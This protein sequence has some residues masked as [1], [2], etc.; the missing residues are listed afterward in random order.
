MDQKNVSENESINLLEIFSVLIKHRKLIIT[1]TLLSVV[2]VLIFS[3]LS[4]I[5]PND[6]SFLP[7]EYT[8]KSIVK[9]NSDSSSDNI[10]TMINASG[11]GS[12]AGL[13][14]ISTGGNS[15]AAWAIELCKTR[16]VLDEI[17]NEFDL[18]EKYTRKSKYPV[19]DARK[20]ILKNLNIEESEDTGSLIIKYTD[21]DKYLAA[22]IVNKLVDILEAS[23][24]KIDKKNNETDI[25]ILFKKVNDKKIYIKQ[26][27]DQLTEFQK[28]YDILDPYIMSEEITRKAMDLRSN[29][30]SKESELDFLKSNFSSNSPKVFNKELELQAAKKLLEDVQEGRGSAKIPA[31]SEMPGLIVEYEEKKT[32]IDAQRAIYTALLQQYEMLRLKQTGTTPTFQVIEKAEI[33]LI[34]SGPSRGKICII[35][36]FIGFFFSIVLAFLK[37]F[38]LNLK[39]DPEAMAKLKGVK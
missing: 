27:V 24:S 30:N 31:L 29:V 36:T 22:N 8:G 9:I 13:L 4:L 25:A 32:Y 6:K 39:N 15:N 23:F 19:V 14:G 26:L 7:N 16:T 3:V 2:L 20:M 12:M 38:W 33:P 35:V 28:R 1:L 34:K 18:Q 5:L 17:T 11:M 21:K 37:E 10:S